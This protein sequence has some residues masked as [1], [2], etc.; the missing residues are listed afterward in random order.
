M[1]R[2]T[3]LA[4]LV[5]IVMYCNVFSFHLKQQTRVTTSTTT[6]SMAGGRSPTEK[7]LS[8]RQMFRSLRD[9][10]VAAAEKPGFIEVKDADA[11]SF[12]CIIFYS[13]DVIDSFLLFVWLWNVFYRK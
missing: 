13:F 10:F 6:I 3:I 5:T 2:T 11:V 4:L 1:S 8:Q 12:L 9:K 7:N